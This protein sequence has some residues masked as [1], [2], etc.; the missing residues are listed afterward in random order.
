[1]ESFDSLKVKE[2]VNFLKLLQNQENNYVFLTMAHL[3]TSV[4]YWSLTSAILLDSLDEIYP[5]SARI[6]IIN[7]LE[8]VYDKRTGGFAGNVDVHEAHILF[9]L[10]GIQILIILLGRGVFPD[11]FNLNLTVKCNFLFCQFIIL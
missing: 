7:F 9:T 5:Q 4:I 11:W 1:M 8:S 6:Q 3:K 2:H 10:S